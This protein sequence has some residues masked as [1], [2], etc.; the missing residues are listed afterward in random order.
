[1]VTTLKTMYYFSQVQDLAQWTIKL[2]GIVWSVITLAIAPT[3]GL[4]ITA[5]TMTTETEIEFR[6]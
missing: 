2:C 5:L 1:M 6:H 3:T 4:S